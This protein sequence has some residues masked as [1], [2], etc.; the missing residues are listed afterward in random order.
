MLFSTD[1]GDRSIRRRD[2]TIYLLYNCRGVFGSPFRGNLARA[3]W[4]HGIEDTD[5]LD[6]VGYLFF[7]NSL[8]VMIHHLCPIKKDI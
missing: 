6:D 3:R 5:T 8:A 4:A 1:F 7:F 2:N